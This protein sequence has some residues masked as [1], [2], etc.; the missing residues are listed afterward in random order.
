MRDVNFGMLKNNFEHFF[1]SVCEHSEFSQYILFVSFYA[2]TIK[3]IGN[4]TKK[5]LYASPLVWGIKWDK[6]WF[7]NNQPQ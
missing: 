7:E 5:I 4:D 1:T 2:T 3:K 6:F